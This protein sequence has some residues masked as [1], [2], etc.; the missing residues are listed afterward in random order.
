MKTER[1]ARRL[2]R[3]GAILLALAGTA[4]AAATEDID[5]RLRRLKSQDYEVQGLFMVEASSPVVWGVLTDYERIPD[6]VAS[7]RRSRVLESRADG[8]EIVEQEAVAGF[9]LTR[10]IRVT[11]EVRREPE[12]LAFTDLRREDFRRYEGSWK[13][14][15]AAGGT[16]V[17]Y[18]L[19]ARPNFLAPGILLRAAMR[20]GARELLAEVRSE[21]LRRV[22]PANTV[23]P[24]TTSLPTL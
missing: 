5:V 4:R 20:R 18:R 2:L 1:T 9:A 22:A 14:Q 6:F 11:L 12:N 24:S 19:S 15:P 13:T 8:A 10:T 17:A 21:I 7:M 3:L 23:K 16:L